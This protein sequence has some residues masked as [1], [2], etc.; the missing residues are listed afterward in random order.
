MKIKEIF[1]KSI[2]II[3]LGWFIIFL[4]EYFFPKSIYAEVIIPIV[5]LLKVIFFVYQSYYI[6]MKVIEHNVSYHRF[7]IIT[8]INIFFI[9][10]S[11]AVD[12]A[13]IYHINSASF[14]GVNTD[15][16]LGETIF[17]WFYFSV[18]NYT[19]FGYGEILPKTIPS[20][21]LVIM[22][23]LISFMTILYVLTDFVTLKQSIEESNFMKKRKE[24]PAITSKGKH[25]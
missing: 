21:S 15:F 20:K 17:E 18:L 19:N 24:K 7:L 14:E 13:S 8:T 23:D 6:V 16:S 2:V 25:D 12:Y 22:Q 3:F 9:I 11:F 1:I 4:D 5:A 10:C